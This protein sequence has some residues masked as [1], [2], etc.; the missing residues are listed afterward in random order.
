MPASRP[1]LEL[2]WPGKDQ[3]LLTPADQEGRPVWVPPD[4]PAAHEVRLTEFTGAYGEVNQ[5]DPYADNLVFGGDSLDVLRVL[6]EVPEFRRHY[7][8]KVKLIYCDPPFGSNQAFVHYDDWMAHSTWLSFMRDRLL[9]MKDLLSPDGTVWF[10]LDNNEAHRM[11]CLMDEV[12]GAEQYINTVV[13]K[14]TTAK[15]LARLGMGTM[16]D[17]ILVYGNHEASGLNP[18]LLPYSEDYLKAKYSNEDERGRYTLGDLTAGS[19]R[20]NLDSGQ[21]WRGYNPSDR[22]RCRAAPIGPLL[23][24]GYSASELD[25]LTMREKLDLLDEHGFIAAPKTP[26]AAPRFKR[27]LDADG[28]VA[29]G[30][31]WTD[32][33]V[34]NSQGKE[35]VGYDTQKPEVLLHRVISM[36]ST[37]GDVVMDLFAGSGT[38]AAVAHKM[39]RRWVTADILPH[40]VEAFVVPRL[41]NVIEGADPGGVTKDVGWDGGG[42]FRTVTVGPSMYEVTPVGVMLAEWATNGRFAQAVAGQLGFTFQ[43][44]AAPLCGVRGRMRLAVLDGAVGPEEVREIVAALADSER[45]TVVA[46]V[47]LPDAEETLTGLSKGS[48]IRKAPRDLLADH[49]RRGRRGNRKTQD[50]QSAGGA[51]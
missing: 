21:E 13:W 29:L 15:S 11:R 42:G 3:F 20:P 41:R 39:G 12:F 32:I 6:C 22:K 50:V 36:G 4:H 45:V 28:G 26:G 43:P 40:T 23:Q 19:H 49:V 31:L 18:I 5:A 34:I 1:R 8:G 33:N 9:L 46:K 17:N 14:R 10:H 51:G 37:P 27:Y 25:A 7:R 16:Y 38:T 24:L 47:I 30:D 44:D 2:V 35:R 48:K